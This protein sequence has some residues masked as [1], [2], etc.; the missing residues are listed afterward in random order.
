[1][2]PVGVF[3]NEPPDFDHSNVCVRIAAVDPSCEIE[4]KNLPE[5][6]IYNKTRM[7]TTFKYIW[8]AMF[9]K[10]AYDMVVCI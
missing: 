5:S 8:E 10:T 7:N 3:D 9:K 4:E 2:G 1:M 6:Q